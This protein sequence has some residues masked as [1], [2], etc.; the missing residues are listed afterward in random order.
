MHNLDFI[1]VFEDDAIPCMDCKQILTKQLQHIP[2]DVDLLKLGHLGNVKPPIEFNDCFEVPVLSFGSHAYIVFKQ[3]YGKFIEN[4]YRDM[5]I[6]RL[7]MN[8]KGGG[9]IYQSIDMAFTQ[10][11][12]ISEKTIHD[13][14]AYIDLLAKQHKLDNFKLS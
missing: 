11:N 2:N 6:D 7:A 14:K 1:C 5:H 9:K 10:Y 4:A 3:Y 12:D 13:N 8:V